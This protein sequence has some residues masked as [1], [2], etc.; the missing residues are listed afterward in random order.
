LQTKH[1][2]IFQPGNRRVKGA[3]GSTI[4]EVASDAGIFLR[5]DCGGNGTC[6]KCSVSVE[7]HGKLSSETL[8]RE[9]IGF[10]E[11][12][13]TLDCLACQTLITEPV[14]ITVSGQPSEGG[15][16]KGKSIIKEKFP[17]APLTDR[18]FFNLKMAK[19]NRLSFGDDLAGLI[20]DEIERDTGQRVFFKEPASLYQLSLPDNADSDITLV[21][22]A[23]RGV[24]SVFTGQKLNTDCHGSQEETASPWTSGQP[25]LLPIFVI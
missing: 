20:T 19:K 3:V 8:D 7:P 21:Y 16:S 6:G 1:E 17:V 10:E 2:I 22:H 24:T 4:Q 23:A 25:A 9:D 13:L 11:K 5:G 12:S 18:Y 15:I 14:S